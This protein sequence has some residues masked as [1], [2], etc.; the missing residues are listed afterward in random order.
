MNQI[1]LLEFSLKFMLKVNL[2]NHFGKN[3][4]IKILNYG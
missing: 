1:D 4:L 3:T 2:I